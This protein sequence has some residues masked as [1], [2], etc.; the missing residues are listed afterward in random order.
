VDL[1]EAIVNSCDSYFYQASLVLGPET[2]SQYSRKLGLGRKLDV[3]LIGELEGFVPDAAWKRENK[4]ELWYEGDTLNLAIGQGYLLVTPLQLNSLTNLIAN[5]GVL[6]KPYVVSRILSA[7]NDEVHYDRKPE[8]LFESGID[9]AHFEFV[10]EAMR[11]VVTKGTAKWGGAV[12]STQAAGK[13]SSAETSAQ[14]THS[15]YT[16]FAPYQPADPAE[17]I[18]VTTIVE[19]GGAGSASAAPISSEIIEAVFSNSDLETAR[20]NIWKK[21]AE[22]SRK[23]GDVASAE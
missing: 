11:G 12:L 20:R 17:M 19:F 22:S 6:Y 3:D 4:G 16:A 15:W 18:S 13:T 10:L 1:H 2:I 7:K 8:L 21:R 14:E 5:K 9:S 23:K